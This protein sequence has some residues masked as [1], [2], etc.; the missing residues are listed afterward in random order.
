MSRFSFVLTSLFAISGLV[1]LI[2]IWTEAAPAHA[3]VSEELRARA[4][5]IKAACRKD[6]ERLCAGTLPGGHRIMSC[7]RDHAGSL[8]PDCAQGLA[9]AKAYKDRAN[10][11]ADLPLK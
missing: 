1:M 7:L 6:Y 5:A 2:N 8:S 3:Q 9:M 10:G 11:T 4:N